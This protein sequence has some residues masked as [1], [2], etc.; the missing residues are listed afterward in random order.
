MENVQDE[1]AERGTFERSVVR[2]QFI[3]NTAARPH[4]ALRPVTAMHDNQ[5]N[6]T[7]QIFR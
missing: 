3:E 4:I 1:L 5:Q 2:A 7:F 6:D